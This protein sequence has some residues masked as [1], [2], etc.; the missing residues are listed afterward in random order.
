MEL[1]IGQ[2]L[3]YH[4]ALSMLECPPEHLQGNSI[5][6]C[7]CSNGIW[8]T[9]DFFEDIFI[10]HYSLQ[11]PARYESAERQWCWEVEEAELFTSAGDAVRLRVT[12]VKFRDIETP[13]QLRLK[14]GPPE[15]MLL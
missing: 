4:Q 14:G 15:S 2:V 3:A 6:Y 10:P 11:Q 5:R 7:W 8:V 12:D 1:H 13:A 9:L